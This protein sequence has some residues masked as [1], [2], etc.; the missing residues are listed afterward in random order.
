M[1]TYGVKYIVSKALV[2]LVAA[3]LSL[4]AVSPAICCCAGIPSESQCCCQRTTQAT[5][6]PCCPCTETCSCERAEGSLPAL[7]ERPSQAG[8][9]LAQPLAG[10]FLNS[11]EF[12]VCPS[13]AVDWPVVIS[14]S[15][16]CIAHCRFDL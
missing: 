14:G 8:D 7:P 12:Q 11:G 6:Q 15:E 1:L 9:D 3:L 10:T 4:Q 13:L 16:R 2:W 5:D